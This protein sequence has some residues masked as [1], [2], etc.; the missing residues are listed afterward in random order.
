MTREVFLLYIRDKIVLISFFMFCLGV[1]IFNMAIDLEIEEVEIDTNE[2]KKLE[3]S[4]FEKARYYLKI[5][6]NNNIYFYSDKLILNQTEEKMSFTGPN[7]VI[8]TEEQDS[9]YYNA[10]MGSYDIGKK[11]LLLE[12]NILLRSKNVNI[13]SRELK[14]DGEIKKIFLNKEIY[15]EIQNHEDL[16][17]LNI[18]SD[19]ATFDLNL[20]EFKYQKNVKGKIKRARKYE[21]PVEFSTNSLLFNISTEKIFL[22]GLVSIK[23]REMIGT[24]KKGNIFLENY[25]KKFKYFSLYDDVVFKRKSIG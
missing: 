17:K 22:D 2:K 20:K 6:G 13:R 21:F 23:Y 8:F 5:E 7:G 24:S 11:R 25:N 12:K 1:F 4:F 16:F 9:F 19:F 15:T 14:Y 10:E 3:L 18:S